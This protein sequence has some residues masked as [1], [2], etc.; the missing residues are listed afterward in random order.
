MPKEVLDFNQAFTIY[1]NDIFAYNYHYIEKY[2]NEH[3]LNKYKITT[4]KQLESDCKFNIEELIQSTYE[5]YLDSVIQNKKFEDTF[6]GAKLHWLIND[7]KINGLSYPPQGIITSEKNFSPHPGTFRFA[8]LYLQNLYNKRFE[9]T[10]VVVL[11]LYNKTNYQPLTFYRWLEECTTG[12]LRKDR[13]ISIARTE[14][15]YLE[16]HETNNHHDEIIETHD[17]DL[18]ELYQK[19]YPYFFVHPNL[20]DQY[21]NNIKDNL[22]NFHLRWLNTSVFNIPALSR[23]EGVSIYVH[24]DV[25]MNVSIFCFLSLL[26]LTDAVLYTDDKKIVIF[27]NRHVDTKKLLKDVVIESTDY[28][29]DNFLWTNCKTEL[30]SLKGVWYDF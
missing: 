19:K 21:R 5:H 24:P 7:I 26:N 12:F 10:K 14:S 25:K 15:N 6:D 2:F 3:Y 9:N 23:Y 4:Y 17:K 16:V 30:S 8:A 1:E 29:L 20:E 18:Q 22:D 28:F 13:Q 11:D 27:N